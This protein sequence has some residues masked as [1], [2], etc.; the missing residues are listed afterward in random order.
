MAVNETTVMS[1]LPSNFSLGLPEKQGSPQFDILL[2]CLICL[3]FCFFPDFVKI[4]DCFLKSAF[5]SIPMVLSVIISRM[6]LKNILS[7]IFVKKVHK[8][9]RLR[10]S[11]RVTTNAQ[12]LRKVRNF[13]LNPMRSYN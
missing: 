6:Q 2:F 1:R 8:N 4:T 11:H 12:I 10:G 7:Y 5:I 13:I 9:S 3:S